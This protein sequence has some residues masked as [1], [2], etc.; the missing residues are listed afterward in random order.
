MKKYESKFEESGKYVLKIGDSFHPEIGGFVTITNI[1]LMYSGRK[2]EGLVHFDF[3]DLNDKQ[4][5]AQESIS[6]FA[7]NYL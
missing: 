1:E 4:G 7:K 5:S 3:V 2:Y 6:N